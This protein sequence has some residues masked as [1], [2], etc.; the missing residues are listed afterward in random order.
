MPL[1]ARG[2]E[3][4]ERLP[5]AAPRESTG[6]IGCEIARREELCVGCGRCASV[7][8]SGATSE[9]SRFDPA[10]L[11]AAP[12]GSRRGALGAALRRI[13]RH[14]PSG[15]IDV[16]ERIRTFRSVSFERELCLGCGACA[17]VCPTGA[18]EARPVPASEVR[19]AVA[20]GGG[21]G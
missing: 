8:P 9:S 12:A 13:A 10:L 15:A 14:E 19:C 18:I 3:I 20:A 2:R 11:Y 16:P 4:F 7:C 5:K 17:R 6:V 1:T 21:A